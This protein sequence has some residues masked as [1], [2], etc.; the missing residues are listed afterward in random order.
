MYQSQ[1]RNMWSVVRRQLINLRSK[2]FCLSGMAVFG[3]GNHGKA[4]TSAAIKLH[5]DDLHT[6]DF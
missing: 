5:V 3:E 1:V 6:E 2:D 4:H